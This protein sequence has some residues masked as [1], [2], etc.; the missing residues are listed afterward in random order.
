LKRKPKDFFWNLQ[1]PIQP[2]RWT[3]FIQDG[4]YPHTR[5]LPSMFLDVNL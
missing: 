3:Q 2:K 1:T 5:S 4:S